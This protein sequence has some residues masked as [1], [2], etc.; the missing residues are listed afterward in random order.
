MLC[1]VSG[2]EEDQAVKSIKV[3]YLSMRT[4][5]ISIDHMDQAEL[6]ES[7]DRPPVGRFTA[8]GVLG[9]LRLFRVDLAIIGPQPEEPQNGAA[10]GRSHSQDVLQTIPDLVKLPEEELG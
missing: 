5:H 9:D 8:T 6:P 3:G 10:L 1:Q 2:Q 7:P 4:D